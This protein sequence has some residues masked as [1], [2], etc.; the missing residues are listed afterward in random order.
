MG[1]AS[2]VLRQKFKIQLDVEKL[3]DFIADKVIETIRNEKDRKGNTIFDAELDEAYF[4]IDKLVITGSYDTGYTSYF[5]PATRWEPAEYDLEREYIGKD[6][7][8]LS[9]LPKEIK[10]LLTVSDVDEDE[11]DMEFPEN[12]Y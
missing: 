12:E 4:D 5:C 3:S 9:N 1:K 10:D 8:I 11:D 2:G 7:W 6:P